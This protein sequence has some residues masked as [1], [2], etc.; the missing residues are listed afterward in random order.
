VRVPKPQEEVATFYAVMIKTDYMQKETF[1]RNFWDGFK[2]LLGKGHVIKVCI[3]IS[4][5]TARHLAIAGAAGVIGF[6]PHVSS[7][8][9]ISRIGV[10]C[11]S[12]G[13][14]TCMMR[15][16]IT[17]CVLWL[18]GPEEVR[19]HGHVRILH[20][21]AGTEEAAVQGGGCL[22]SHPPSVSA[23]THRKSNSIAGHAASQQGSLDR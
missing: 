16:N 20:G 11:S 9:C 6:L 13:H 8:D 12:L 10:A 17:L 2:A 19:L 1:N 21:S 3:V 14:A 18:S 7:D 22:V 4:S 23:F 15:A 5:M